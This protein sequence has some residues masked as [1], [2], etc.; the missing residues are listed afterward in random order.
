MSLYEQLVE[1]EKNLTLDKVIDISENLLPENKRFAPWTW[2]NHGVSLLLSEDELNAYML[3]YGEMHEVKCRAAFQNFPFDRIYNNVEIIDWGC[4]QGLASL[5]LM[6]ML[7]DRGLEHFV[8]KI[9]LIEPSQSALNRAK[10]NLCQRVCGSAEVVAINKFLPSNSA[11]PENEVTEFIST[12]PNTIHIFSNIL[13]IPTVNLR[14]LSQIISNNNRMTYV[15]CVGPQNR[16][17]WRINVFEGY[18]RYKKENLFTNIEETNYAYTHRTNHPITCKTKGFYFE[19]NIPHWNGTNKYQKLENKVVD[20]QYIDDYSSAS[21]L[22]KDIFPQYLLS[23][24]EKIHNQLEQDDKLFIRPNIN[25]D[26][27]DLVLY[28]PQVGIVLFDI[29]DDCFPS[30]NSKDEKEIQRK[31]KELYYTVDAYANRLID[32]HIASLREKIIED[33]KYLNIVRKVTVFT[34]YTQKEIEAFFNFKHPYIFLIS[35]D[36]IEKNLYHNIAIDRRNPNFTNSFAQTFLNLISSEWH[37]YKDGKQIILNSKQALLAKSVES[38][39]RKIKG[40]AGSGKTLVMTYRAVSAMIRTGKP[41]LIITYNITLRNYI[42][43]RLNQIPA[44][45][46]WNNVTIL[47]YHEFFNSQALNVGRRVKGLQAYNNLSYFSGAKVHKYSAIFIDEVQDFHEKWLRILHDTFLDEKGEFVV[48]GDK[49]QNIFHRQ[50]GD[51]NEPIIPYVSGRWNES[52]NDTQRF[53]NGKIFNLTQR[54][55]AKFIDTT[56]NVAL[57]LDMESDQFINYALIDSNTPVEKMGKWC[58]DTVKKFGLS[59]ERTVVLASTSDILQ[60]IDLGYRQCSSKET[61]ITFA[62]M[63]QY[64]MIRQKG[65][66]YFKRNDKA[67]SKAKKL[68]FT[69]DAECLKLSTIHSFKGWEADNIILFI[70]KPESIKS[71]PKTPKLICEAP[72]KTLSPEIIYTAITRA[73]KSL[74]IF[75]LGNM[76]YDEFFKNNI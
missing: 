40:I 62:S 27:P 35:E 34:K 72:L 13:D 76:T 39:H 67:L 73:R 3:A 4:G 69:M 61:K 22:F 48:F 21:I 50:M 55:Y 75:N 37:S 10:I 30:I 29:K 24:Y 53:I 42:R 66:A 8:K 23:V 46:S 26:T 5:V 58:M 1:N 63:E 31:K 14:K 38:A 17:S 64:D 41:V 33:N 25:G 57:Q 32:L 28:K 44:D 43:Y 19:S 9:T 12:Q 59:L 74:F 20:N 15:I 45:F 68:H 7:S 36:G 16:N 70:Q 60:A 6:E 71:D 52:L 18:F 49:A 11:V 65:P 2:L 54:F 56:T 47:N 51:D